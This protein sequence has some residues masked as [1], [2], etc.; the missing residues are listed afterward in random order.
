MVWF[1]FAVLLALGGAASLVFLRSK[2][3]QWSGIGALA[4]A[5]A[6][7]IPAFLFIVPPRQIGIPI[8]FGL[9][10]DP[11][12]SGPH[13]RAPWTSVELMDMTIQVDDNLGDDRTEVR[14]GNQSVA[15]V[16]NQVRW[17]VKSE[18]ATELFAA[19]KSFDNIGRAIEEPEVFSALSKAMAGYDPLD[20]S[21]PDNATLEVEVKRAMEAEL[22]DRLVIHSVKIQKIDFDALTQSRLDALLAEQGNTRIAEQKQRTAEKEAEANRILAESV[23]NDPNVIVAN[24]L[25]DVSGAAPGTFPAGFQCWPGSNGS[26]VIPA[27]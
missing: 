3:G 22:N 23:S 5:V 25:K 15:F 12:Q 24:C 17:S 2:P 21:R 10:G 11:L 27:R 16:Q 14:L 20:P 18:A 6:M 26:V 19:H 1:V 13:L 4:V 9:T 8:T 7:L